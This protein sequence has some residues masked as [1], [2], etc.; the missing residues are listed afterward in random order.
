MQEDQDESDNEDD[1]EDS[2]DQSM[3]SDSSESNEKMVP[4]NLAISKQKTIDP[5]KS[6]NMNED[7]S[8]LVL[9]N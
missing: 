3:L 6:K 9:E 5:R 4:P 2:N 1:G 7:V 8:D